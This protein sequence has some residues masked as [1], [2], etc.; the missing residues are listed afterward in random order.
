MAKKL[1]DYYNKSTAV[2][3]ADKIQTVLPSFNK[4]KF[5]SMVDK[6]VRG[7]EFLA[8]Q[9]VF[10]SAF[11]E[12]LGADYSKNIKLFSKILEPKLTTDTGMFTVGYWL[13]PIGRYV[14]KHGTEDFV[15]SM[16]F[17][18]ELTQRFTGEFAVRPLI[19]KY[20]KRASKIMLK[21]SKDKSVHVRR[22]ASEGMRIN[23]PWAKK[24]TVCMDEFHT[25]KQ[26]LNNLKSDPSKF[27]QKSV[28]NNLNDLYKNFPNKANEIIRD[29][30][31]KTP[32][33]QTQWIIN[34]G[35]RSTRK[36]KK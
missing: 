30:Q 18:H 35:L 9:D 24:S 34:H 11:E 10:V 27:V 7:K 33:K 28:G 29:W 12:C 25:Y 3:V 19:A 31:K 5:V 1:K 21:W 26:I 14:E 6:G 32:S 17:I 23:L 36:V 13:W 4:S 16:E 15:A 20:P 8:R 22:L 2:L